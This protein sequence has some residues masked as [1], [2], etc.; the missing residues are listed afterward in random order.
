MI[1]KIYLKCY[2]CLQRFFES[3]DIDENVNDRICRFCGK[4][5]I[6][7]SADQKLNHEDRTPDIKFHRSRNEKN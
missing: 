2:S 1:E 6:E 4:K 7:I 5:T 3:V